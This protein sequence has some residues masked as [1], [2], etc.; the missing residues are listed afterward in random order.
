MAPSNP[1]PTASGSVAL[2]P[3]ALYEILLRLPAKEL[4]RLR[5]VCR[6]W[7]ALTSD[8]FFVAAHKSR[9]TGPLLAI[10]YFDD[11]DVHGV[12]I[13]DLSGSVLRRIPCTAGDIVNEDE[14]GNVKTLFRSSE[15]GIS[16]LRTRLDLICFTRVFHP[17]VLWV[18]N[19]ATGATL[20]L[21]RCCS[22][23]FA[24]DQEEIYYRNVHLNA[25]G[26]VSSTGEYKALR[27]SRHDNPGAR[28]LCELI[29]LDGTNH[30]GW[31]RKHSP[32]ALI[33]TSRERCV[34]I[35]G[36]VYFL[37]DFRS[38]YSE[39]GVITFELGSIA[40]FNLETEEWMGTLL[41]PVAVRR[42]VQESEKFSYLDLDMQLSLADLDGC[43]VTV[44][45]I[46]NTSMDLWFLTDFE[47]GVWVKK[48]SMPLQVARLFVYPLLLLDD[49]RIL[50]RYGMS[51]LQIYDPRTDT[52]ADAMEVRDS[53]SI[54]I[55]TGSL[56][57]L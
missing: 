6:S 12:D 49:G 39:L 16:L 10:P 14:S 7:R 19:P 4:C 21:P 2:H 51:F 41:G 24:H 37:M 38:T 42:F 13:V 22:E 5:A 45:N 36:V 15:I 27:I 43:L 53:R 25:F 8:P 55:Y 9:H 52:H 11:S 28:Q 20:T 40:S 18:L 1:R 34:V 44:H 32:P 33:C 56:L 31:R 46:H 23:E 3:D 30:G 17:L 54:G 48:Y 29:S 57:G 50:F 26:Q 35:D 47:E